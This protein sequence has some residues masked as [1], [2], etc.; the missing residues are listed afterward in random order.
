MSH[1][2]RAVLAWHESLSPDTVTDPIVVNGPRGAGTLTPAAF[3]DWAE[4]S[5]ISLRVVALHPVS[6]RVLVA[7]QEARWPSSP[8][9]SPVATVFRVSG[10]RVSAALRFPDLP[11]AMAFADLYAALAATE[12]A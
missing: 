3:A 6:D 9:W 5:G 8:S 7:A 11:A 4:R 12:G 1:A 2:E 10:D